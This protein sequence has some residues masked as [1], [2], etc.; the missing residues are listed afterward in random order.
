MAE[1]ETAVPRV[2]GRNEMLVINAVQTLAATGA[3]L[4]EQAVITATVQSMTAP[5]GKRDRRREFARRALIGLIERGA[6]VIAD[7][8]VT[9]RH[10]RQVASGAV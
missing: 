2:V 5:V 8:V 3:V 4:T 7:G 1:A 9:A 6:L 10:T